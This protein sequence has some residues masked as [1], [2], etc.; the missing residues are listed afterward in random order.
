MVTARKA[1][2]KY[3]IKTSRVFLNLV[4]S[5]RRGHTNMLPLSPNCHGCAA[6]FIYF[7]V[8]KKRSKSRSFPYPHDGKERCCAGGEHVVKVL[9][10][11]WT[12][13]PS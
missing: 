1:G 13:E 10:S 6:A 9:G 8:S 2:G 5:E 11:E 4:I 3:G 12:A 7:S